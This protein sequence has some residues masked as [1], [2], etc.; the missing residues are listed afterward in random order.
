MAASALR[1]KKILLYSVYGLVALVV[2]LLQYSAFATVPLGRGT[3]SFFL[4]VVFSAAV[5]FREWAG[6]FY[7]LVCGF[8]MDMVSGEAIGFH[9][10]ALFTICL[11]A[12]YMISHF[13]RKQFLSSALVLVGCT[14]VFYPAKW[15]CLWLLPGREEAALYLIRVTLPSMTATALISLPIYWLLRA[16]AR[17]LVQ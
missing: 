14:V 10:I 12:G 5:L 9:A 16:M 8:A 7:G 6:A 1:K 11:F 2:F 15:F 3:V 17:K 13:L 4:P